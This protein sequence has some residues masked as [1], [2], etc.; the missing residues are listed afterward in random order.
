MTTNVLEQTT[1]L[2]LERRQP[3]LRSPTSADAGAPNLRREITPEQ[4]CIL[5]FDRAGS[6]ANVF[7]RATLAELNQH[8]D[9]V[10]AHPELTGLILCSAKKS[11]FIA[12]ADL[13]SIAA[14]TDPARL[15]ELIQFGQAVFNRLAALP[16]PTVAAIHG[17]CVG[18]GFELSLACDW[19]VAT[20]DRATR[21][22]LPETQIGL[23]PAW[24]GST[25]LPRLITLTKALNV[26]LAGKTLVAKQ[27]LKNGMVDS[28]VPVE[29]LLSTALK[30]AQQGKPNRPR[31]SVINSELV[32]RSLAAYLRPKLNKKTRGHY[33]AVQK[34]LEVVTQGINRSVEESMRLELDGIM[35][36]TQSATTR[37]L[38]QLFL[39]QERA[40]KLSAGHPSDSPTEKTR[41]RH[42]AVIGAGVMGS[43]I[44][45]W[46]SAKGLPVIL[47]DIKPEFIAK[48]MS[49]ISKLYSNG[50]KR[51]IFSPTEARA[52]MDR[53]SPAAVEVPMHNVDLVIE[54]A[55][56]DMTLKKQVFRKL[57]AAAGDHTILATNTSAL[58]ISELA[59]SSAHPERVVGIH[60]FNP[61][62]RM[63]LVEVV[64]A[65]A[66][67]PATVQRAI[68]FVQQ[69][70]KLPLLVNDS[71]GFL[72]NRILVP[73]LIEAGLLFEAGATVK[74]IDDAMLDFGM[75]MG[76][77]RLLDEVGLDVAH[78]ISMT[79]AKQYPD[80]LC[81]P[82]ILDKMLKAGFLGK[83]AGRGFYT[84]SKG[85]KTELNPDTN[86]FRTSTSAQNLTRQDLRERMVLLMINEAARC[87]EEQ[88]V[89][90]P[91]DADFGM[92]MGTGFAPF[93]GGPLR[94]ADSE[95]IDK[96]ITAMQRWVKAGVIYFE[97]CALLK[98][99]AGRN[100][101]FY[102]RTT[103]VNFQ[104]SMPPETQRG[105]LARS[106]PEIPGT[107]PTP[108][109]RSNSTNPDD[110]PQLIDTSKMSDGQRAALELTEAARENATG[111]FASR[112]FMG[113]LDLSGISPFPDQS[114]EDRAQGDA[115]LKRL[116][117]FLREHVD[118]DEIDR[119]GEIPQE[120]IDELGKMGAF[121]IKISREYEGLGM[122]QTN[123]SRAAMMLGSY[124]GNLTAL[125]SA[126]QSIGVPQPLI[127]FGTE[128]QKRKFLPRVAKGE[129]SA[130]ALTENGV[131]SDPANMQ[132]HAEP[133]EDGKYFILNGEKLWCTNG[134]KAGV[135]IVMARTPSKM[136]KGKSKKQIT[137]FIV[138]MDSPGVEV[139]HRCHFMGLRALYNGVV[140]FK[141]VRVPRENIVLAEGKG[142]RV[143]LTTLN[144][145]RLTLPAA[146]VGLSKQCLQISKKWAGERAQWGNA[147]GKHAAIADKIAHMAANTF[148]MEAM[149]LLTSGLV[150]RDKHADIRLEAA[151][152][153][154]WG[155]ETAWQIV[156]ET[157]QIRGGRGYETADSLRARGEEAVPI[158]R[159]MRD[160]RINTIF[161]GSSEIMRLFV[162]REAL[163][164]HLKVAAAA[165]D[166]RLPLSKRARAAFKAACFYARW[167]P[168]QWLPFNSAKIPGLDAKL[169]KHLRYAA[170]TSRKLSRSL[171]HSMAR[172]G[173]KLER[174][175]V[176]LGRFVDIGAELFAITASCLRA[177]A[178]IKANG[179][180]PEVVELVD[181]FCNSARLRIAHLFRDLHQNADRSGYRVAQKVLEGQKDWLFDGILQ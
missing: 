64:R 164:P 60:F 141:D 112:M 44:A 127:L 11:I 120:V 178:L 173:P 110:A 143:A 51:H 18:G 68:Q 19:R 22:G 89:S 138:E 35:E 156:D 180:S 97:P 171:F 165:L 78:H 111:S 87:L 125:L 124:C 80:R 172:F 123:Y 20:T 83:K 142:L 101:Q 174:Q 77:M 32:A 167:Y 10:A 40:K 155:S 52:G 74:D 129:I 15:R 50:V 131:G 61:V 166:S 158:E 148:A 90:A 169:A 5:T 128:E 93:H 153:K 30:K 53:V 17:A 34:A 114:P 12:G 99:M 163:D 38:I 48:G 159:L 8:L 39:L 49:N 130:F 92:V 140:R 105:S 85:G 67:N 81:V 119:T 1:A 179:K 108:E 96:I 37:N 69:I 46:L 145:G 160:C 139:V 157:M 62:H 3:S 104:K 132:T 2:N 135:I 162:A 71:P 82:A 102:D 151:M 144:T 66:T 136:V 88:V 103:V 168:Q 109:P 9:F 58:S 122:S 152:C 31:H 161:E 106:E 175:Q 21:I 13:H 116:E 113:K 24:G 6:S 63:Q 7:D 42:C 94:Y 57:E 147:I 54:A 176:L 26:I 23:I 14:E 76:P 47:R 107:P 33:P 28:I 59:A 121:G 133:T 134:T 154:L 86:S 55:V 150:S 16:I 95:G 117:T 100:A 126:H 146:C 98:E 72:V 170:K 65:P 115:F 75:P 73:Y 149:T 36:L 41:V 4:I 177:Q 181:Y 137:A 70:G 27:A 43:G 45:Q 91:E 29:Y 56:E 25:R 118:P 84:H 79:L